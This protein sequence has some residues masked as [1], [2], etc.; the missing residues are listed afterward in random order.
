MRPLSPLQMIALGFVLVLVGVLLPLLMVLGVIPPGFALSFIS[1][2]ASF[3]GL[4]LGITGSAMY[5]RL[6][7]P[8]DGN[9]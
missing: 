9:H 6:K 3:C 5:V 4:L 2:A 7:R 1:Y 8:P